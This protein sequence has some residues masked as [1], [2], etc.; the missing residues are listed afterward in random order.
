MKLAIITWLFILHAVPQPVVNWATK[1]KLQIIAQ[2]RE[3]LLDRCIERGIE[4]RY[5]FEMRFCESGYLW[6]DDCEDQFVEIRSIHYDPL[7]ETYRVNA[8]RLDDINKPTSQTFTS[9][10]DAIRAL[11]SLTPIALAELRR[12]VEPDNKDKEYV[13]VRVISECKGSIGSSL[14][15]I[16]NFLTLGLVKI[17]R[18]DSGW[19]A[20]YLND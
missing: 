3:E 7:Y 18:F 9:R 17:N 16:S 14:L 5:R 19:V 11:T 2:G 10:E 8:D 4:V 20:F 1:D 13:G 12:G 6:F 15:D